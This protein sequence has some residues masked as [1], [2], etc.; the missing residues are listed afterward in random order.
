MWGDILFLLKFDYSENIK[1]LKYKKMSLSEQL[2]N[3]GFHWPPGM[4]GTIQCSGFTAKEI[5]IELEIQYPTHAYNLYPHWYEWDDTTGWT[6]RTGSEQG[7][8]WEID[9]YPYHQ[10]SQTN[11]PP[12]NIYDQANGVYHPIINI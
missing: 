1:P 11:K 4:G 8:K 5:V 7:L 10:N 12:R 3:I 6:P 9:I 2:Q